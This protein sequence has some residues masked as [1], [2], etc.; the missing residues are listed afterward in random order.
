MAII[1]GRDSAPIYLE[2]ADATNGTC[3]SNSGN[4]TCSSNQHTGG[5]SNHTSPF[6]LPFP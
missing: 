6:I 1:L 2:Q 3:T 5:Y 4:T